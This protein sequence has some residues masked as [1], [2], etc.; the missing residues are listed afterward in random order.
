MSSLDL[1]HPVLCIKG[2]EHIASQ[3]LT[4]R[5]LLPRDGLTF[6]SCLGIGTPKNKSICRVSQAR[7]QMRGVT[8]GSSFEMKPLKKRMSL[9]S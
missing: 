8:F 3:K 6:I 7:S 5:L 2:Y 1:I 9:Q 4:E